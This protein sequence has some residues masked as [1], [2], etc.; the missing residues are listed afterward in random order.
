LEGFAG[1]CNPSH[2]AL[3]PGGGFVTSEKGLPRVKEY[4]PDGTLR[5]VVAGSEGFA[6]GS[7]G[8]DLATDPGGRVYVLDPVARAVRVFVPGKAKE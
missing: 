1:C 6:P 8:L 5:T 2:F 3:L 4:S 7:V